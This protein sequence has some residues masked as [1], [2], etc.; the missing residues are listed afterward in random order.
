MWNSMILA[1]NCSQCTDEKKCPPHC[2][3][4]MFCPKSDK[5]PDHPLQKVTSEANAKLFAI[6]GS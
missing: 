6:Y 1:K 3:L 4:S 5:K 2:Q